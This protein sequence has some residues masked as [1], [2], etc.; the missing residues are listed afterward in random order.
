[1]ISE[2]HLHHVGYVVE[3]IDAC[4]EGF[5]RSLNAQWDG[6]VFTDP[7]QAAAVTFLYPGAAG[8][9]AI[10]LVEPRGEKAPTRR[11][12]KNG[13]GLHHI[14]YEVENLAATLAAWNNSEARIIRPALPAVAFGSRP[15]AWAYTRY[16]L[17]VEL[18]EANEQPCSSTASLAPVQP[19][20]A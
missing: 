5:A 13:G 9:P 10:E 17:L 3:S 2:G 18:L 4:V 7:H 8:D 16:G 15:I 12:L 11:F 20:R 6:K 19:E 1:M 14:C